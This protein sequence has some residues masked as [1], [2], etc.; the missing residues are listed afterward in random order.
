MSRSWVLGLWTLYFVLIVSSGVDRSNDKVQRRKTKN[1][2]SI[3]RSRA[4]HLF[5]RPSQRE[6]KFLIAAFE[7]C[8]PQLLQEI[9]S[10]RFAGSTIIT[11]VGRPQPLVGPH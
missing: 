9:S 1:L 2:F 10:F 11:L 4:A 3:I 5:N 8:I 7:P 6:R